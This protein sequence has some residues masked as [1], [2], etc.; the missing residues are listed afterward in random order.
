MSMETETPTPTPEQLETLWHTLGM[1]A[2]TASHGK[3]RDTYRNSYCAGPGHH[4]QPIID[5]LVTLGWM[6][7]APRNIDGWRHQYMATEAGKAVA[8]AHRPT[9]P[10]RLP[11]TNKVA[12]GLFA[13]GEQ[14]A[15]RC[16]SPEKR[17]AEIDAALR[18]IKRLHEVKT[19]R[20]PLGWHSR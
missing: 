4:A 20:A 9:K 8:W 5:G 3:Q 11:L 16:D 1:N 6:R 7:Y 13:I 18:W 2:S 19:Y 15:N 12:A 17:T 14:T 10:R